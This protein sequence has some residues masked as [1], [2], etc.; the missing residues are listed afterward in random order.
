MPATTLIALDVDGVV[1]LFARQAKHVK[2]ADI[3]V[4]PVQWHPDVIGRLRAA[5]ARP[6]V[7]GAWLTTWVSEPGLLDELEARTKLRGLVPFR[8]DFPF[9]DHAGRVVGNLF[10][11]QVTLDASSRWWWKFTALDLLRDHLKPRRYAWL[12]D[13]LGKAPGVPFRPGVTPDRFLLRTN[14]GE[15]LRPADLDAL[16]SWLGKR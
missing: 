13:D 14:P 15:G 8:A 16:E 10:P 2:K 11:P 12:D 3:G 7:I 6:D 4:W 1:N 9:R 5:L